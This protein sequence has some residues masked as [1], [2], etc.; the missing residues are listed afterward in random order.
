MV[1]VRESFD[2]LQSLEEMGY[3]RSYTILS[4]EQQVGTDQGTYPTYE[5]INPHSSSLAPSSNQSHK[6]LS[7]CFARVISPDPYFRPIPKTLL[8][9]LQRAPPSQPV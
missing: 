3:R 8:F 9:P 2:I 4:I 1:G 5:Y 7:V 6:S